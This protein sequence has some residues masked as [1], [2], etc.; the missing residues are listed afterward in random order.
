MSVSR[1]GQFSV[2]EPF[3]RSVSP[4]SL[5]LIESLARNT[6]LGRATNVL[7]CRQLPRQQF[8]PPALD[9]RRKLQGV[10]VYDLSS[11]QRPLLNR[12]L[13]AEVLVCCCV[14][15]STVQSVDVRDLLRRKTGL[16]QARS[17]TR[18]LSATG[19][20]RLE[21][22]FVPPRILA[23]IG[24]AA[25]LCSST[26]SLANFLSM[27][28]PISLG[29]ARCLFS[30][31]FWMPLPI[32]ALVLTDLLRVLLPEPSATFPRG[33]DVLLAP[34][35]TARV[36]LEPLQLA[37]SLALPDDTIVLASALRV[38]VPLRFAL[39]RQTITVRLAPLP[40][41][42]AD[43]GLVRLSVAPPICGGGLLVSLAPGPASG[44]GFCDSLLA[45]RRH[46]SLAVRTFGVLGLPNHAVHK[47]GE[48]FPVSRGVYDSAADQLT[49]T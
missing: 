27:S 24:P 23:G 1:L 16:L 19:A 35:T 49:K 14:I 4:L 21:I 44:T 48:H 28:I 18:C 7:L 31:S 29:S 17:K 5:H 15:R 36:V 8:A 30:S 37:G 47:L 33:I 25:F 6:S 41:P 46:D 42:R 38:G 11:N 9:P 32:A 20:L 2:A 12:T 34:C 26:L 3:Y 43:F 40:I 10:S 22:P 45:L 13:A 39:P